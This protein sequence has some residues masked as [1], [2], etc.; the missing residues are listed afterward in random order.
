MKQSNKQNQVSGKQSIKLCLEF[1]PSKTKRPRIILE[2]SKITTAAF[3]TTNHS[4]PNLKHKT[5]DNYS[6]GH[7]S[8]PHHYLKKHSNRK[9]CGVGGS[10]VIKLEFL[11]KTRVT[12]IKWWYFYRPTSKKQ[13][14]LIFFTLYK[15]SLSWFLYTETRDY[16]II[17][18]GWIRQGF[19]ISMR[20][21]FPFFFL[22]CISFIHTPFSSMGFGVL[23]E[24]GRLRQRRRLN[25]WFNLIYFQ[26]KIAIFAR[27][28][29]YNYNLLVGGKSTANNSEWNGEVGTTYAMYYAN[30]SFINQFITL[31]IEFF[32][33][34]YS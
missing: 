18:Q 15:K 2:K 28:L 23:C 17:T 26:T 16:K 30:Q 20:C 6:D 4:Y 5:K 8:I 11:W 19:R 12:H 25:Y 24:V 9:R 34:F 29:C 14:F 10:I 31:S 1:N 27:L 3:W 7:L 33:L 13:P 22:N 21:N 32:F